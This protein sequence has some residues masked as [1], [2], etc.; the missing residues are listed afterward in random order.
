MELRERLAE[1]YVIACERGAWE[2]SALY[3]RMLLALD[4]IEVQQPT[5]DHGS[6]ALT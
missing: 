3:A 4:L 1:L 2:L 6:Q 5:S